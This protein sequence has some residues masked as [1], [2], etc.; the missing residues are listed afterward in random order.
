MGAYLVEYAADELVVRHD[1]VHK[2]L[3]QFTDPAK[4]FVHNI[5]PDD[6]FIS[7]ILDQIGSHTLALSLIHIW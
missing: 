5:V 1:V 7:S 2:A 3:S 4:D 6:Q